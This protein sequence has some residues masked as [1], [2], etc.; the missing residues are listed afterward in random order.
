MPSKKTLEK[1][2]R[3]MFGAIKEIF[4]A[5]GLLLFISGQYALIQPE[6]TMQLSG[7]DERNKKIIP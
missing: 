7:Q 6:M 2:V 1:N 4:I 5:C 3:E